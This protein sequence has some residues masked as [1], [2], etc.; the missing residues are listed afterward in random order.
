MGLSKIWI[1]G[2]AKDGVVATTTLELLAKARTLA[3]TVEVVVHGD[4][5]PLAPDLVYTVPHRCCRWGTSV[6]A[7]PVHAS[8]RLSLLPYRQAVAPT[9][10]CVGPPTTVET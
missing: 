4:A 10:C 3:D 7:S 9:S 6:R 2:E 8:P 1:Y 5:S